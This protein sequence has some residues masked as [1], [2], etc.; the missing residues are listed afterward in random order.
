[1]SRGPLSSVTTA[2]PPRNF[3]RQMNPPNCSRRVALQTGF[4]VTAAVAFGLR[5]ASAEDVVAASVEKAH[6]EIWRRFIDPHD[7]LVDYADDEG[8]FPR[9]TPEECRAGK[10]NALGWWSPIENGSMFNGMYLEG[11]CAR[12]KNTGAA[13][14][15]D[16]ARRLVKGLLRLG[17]LGPPGFIARGVATDGRTPYPMGSNDQTGP[18]L[19]GLW[20]FIQDGLAEP[21]ERAELVQRF[22]EVAR[23]LEST[24]WRMPCNDGA[25]SPFRGTFAGHS[26]EHA[27]RLLFLLKAA[28][29]LTG[30]AHWDELYR[31]ALREPGGEPPTTR[32]EICER[33]MIFHSTKWRESWTG[34]S[35]VIALRGLWE[36]ETDPEVRTAYERGLAASLRLAADG[37]ALCRK[38]DNESRAAFLHDWRVLN[39]WWQPQASE[40]EAVAVAERQSKELGRLSPRRY[41]EFVHVREPLFAAWVVTLCPDRTLV[42]PHRAAILEALGHYR[43]ERL[44]YSQF[45]PAEAAWYRLQLLDKK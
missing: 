45:F 4:A 42:E 9:P 14:D 5:R 22:A 15:R 44:Y 40:A 43:Y 30:D 11:M 1:M 20:R 36:L 18:W 21:A 16:K 6:A 17:S 29:Q 19:Y 8:K 38:F 24:G 34:A 35:G 7:I 3:P 2:F 28:H 23:V 27:P 37:I 33:G 12:W 39:E 26:W 31:K 25:P 32:L 10:P 13:A 41:P